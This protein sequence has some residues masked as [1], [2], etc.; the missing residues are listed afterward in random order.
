MLTMLLA[1]AA[2]GPARQPPASPPCQL[3]QAA[4]ADGRWEGSCRIL[5]R[6]RRIV[7]GRVAAVTSGRW[8]SD[9]DPIEVFDG[10]MTD[11]GSAN[12]PIELEVYRAGRSVL[13]TAYGWF[14][15]VH[16]HENGGEL[17]F[18]VDTSTQAPPSDL[19]REIVKR[20]DAIFSSD[21]VWNR[22]DDRKCAVDATTWSIYCAIERATAEVAGAA[23]HRRPAMEAVRQ[24]VDQRSA[25]RQYSHRLMDY[26][27]DRRTTLADVHSLFAEALRRMEAR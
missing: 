10:D 2:I 16:Y 11:E 26:N 23:H 6:T 17:T 13:R 24:I 12:A 22:A 14:M 5:D 15:I 3:R 19:D 25:G 21:A 20:A 8:R 4:D 18:D 1:L 27:N 9:A 7:L